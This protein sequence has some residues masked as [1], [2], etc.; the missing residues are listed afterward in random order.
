[1]MITLCVRPVDIDIILRRVAY[2][3]PADLIAVMLEAGRIL[4]YVERIG[5]TAEADRVFVPAQHLDLRRAEDL[6]RTGFGEGIA[7]HRMDLDRVGVGLARLRAVAG[8][9]VIIHEVEMI[10]GRRLLAAR[11]IA[12]GHTALLFRGQIDTHGTDSGRHR[13]HRAHRGQHHTGCR[14]QEKRTKFHPRHSFLFYVMNPFAMV[15]K[16]S[17]MH[18]LIVPSYAGVVNLPRPKSK[19]LVSVSA[20]HT[21]LSVI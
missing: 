19:I 20:F 4:Q 8:G 17:L 14:R 16:V 11:H 2:L 7:R 1:M 6:D 10:V 18:H 12:G 5:G 9:A 21:V 3:I 13:R 15:R